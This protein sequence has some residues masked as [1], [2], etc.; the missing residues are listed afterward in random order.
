MGS[1]CSTVAAGSRPNMRPLFLMQRCH[2]TFG[3]RAL[4]TDTL[5]SR[6]LFRQVTF[7]D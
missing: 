3:C 5:A 7:W 1:Q 2:L 4:P 6:R